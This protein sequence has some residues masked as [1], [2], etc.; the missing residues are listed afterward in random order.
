MS[1]SWDLTIVT[2]AASTIAENLKIALLD[3]V[4]TCACKGYVE[5]V[6]QGV[7]LHDSIV[8]TLLVFR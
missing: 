2:I 3:P 8:M 1:V 7:S 4:M 6:W 5:A